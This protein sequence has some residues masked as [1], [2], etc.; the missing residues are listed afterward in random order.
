MSLLSITFPVLPRF[1]FKIKYTYQ[2]AWLHFYEAIRSQI[3]NMIT[4][5]VIINLV[6]KNPKMGWASSRA[7]GIDDMNMLLYAI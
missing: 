3:V 6:S 5:V 4:K 1:T 2:G 7:Q